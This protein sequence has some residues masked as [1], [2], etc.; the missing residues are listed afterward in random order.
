VAR[1]LRASA[2]SAVDGFER[3]VERLHREGVRFVVIGLSGANYYAR[4]ARAL[5]VTHDRDLFLPADSDNTLAAWRA[6]E[7]LNLDLF[8]GDE[9]LDRPRDRLLAERVVA[10]QALTSATDGAGLDVE[11][12]FVMAGFDFERVWKRRRVFRVGEVE[13]PVA[14]LAHIVE[15]KRR[16]GRDKDRLFL[17]THAEALRDLMELERRRQARRKPRPK[18]P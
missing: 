2:L 10:H 14:R 11:F 13:I 8:C 4:S 3:L 9:P 16:A 15:S 18:P 12:T 7:A 1:S 17:A 6:C 5:F